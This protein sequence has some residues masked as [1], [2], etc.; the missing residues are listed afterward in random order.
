[1]PEQR[2]W[3]PLVEFLTAVSG[4]D[5]ELAA[6]TAAAHLAAEQFNAEIGAVIVEGELRA[7]TGF[8]ATRGPAGQLCAAK[9]GASE[10]ELPG[11]GKCELAVAAWAD[12]G[13][14]GRLVIGRVD[15][16]LDP[17]ERH[18]LMGMTR[19]LGLAL[20]NI[21]ALQTERTLRADREREAAERLQLLESLRVRQQLLEVLLDIQRSISHRAALPDVLRKVTDGASTLLGGCAVSLVL[22]DALDPARPIVACAAGE[23]AGGRP[24]PPGAEQLPADAPAADVL[25]ADA[26]V[27]TATV[28]IN[29]VS[30]GALVAESGQARSFAGA[31][32]GTL[33]AFAEHASLALTDA[34]TLE[35]MQE[36][37]HDPLTGLPNRALFLDRLEQALRAA[38][39]TDRQPSVLFID[40]DRFKAVNDTIGHAAGDE[41]LCAVAARLRSCVRSGDTAA[42][43]GGDE[44]AVLLEDAAN[45]L[46]CNRVAERIIAAIRRPFTIDRRE[47]FIGATVGIAAAGTSA[48]AADELLR[49]ADTAMYSAKRAGG[50]RT[51]T[52][53]SQMRDRLIERLELASELQHALARGHLS[54]A[55]Q[56]IVDL[57]S[58]RPTGVEALARWT[59]PGRGVVPPRTFIPIAEEIGIIGAIG[60]WIL[61]AGCRQLR[62]W[63]QVVPD[64][65][66]SVNVSGRQLE[67]DQILDDVE[68]ALR[69]N[70]LPGRALTLE[71]TERALAAGR[72]DIAVRLA[73]LCALDVAIAVDDFGIGYSALRYLRQLPID[74]LKIDKPFIDAIGTDSTEAALSH[75]MLQLASAMRLWTVA[76]GIETVEQLE[77]LRKLECDT[78]QGFLFSTP[79]G[80]DELT[81]YLHASVGDARSEVTGAT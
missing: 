30:A 61:A 28:H 63:R 4:H 9:P 60:H 26:P 43:F 18:L 37:F 12:G 71:I 80:E 8:G 77:Q 5:D 23:T 17:G 15:E 56:P 27:L 73:R 42:R 67:D 3:Q 65:T 47:V 40:L 62:S 36:A 49:N 72:D 45:S 70:G 81:A 7:V 14:T 24:G 54:I 44:F 41:L 46:E 16:P 53:E 38:G 25:A 19:V 34:K 50:G 11:I 74:T 33:D 6:A 59:S 64:L 39:R 79:L 31:D 66:L 76:E 58:R 48:P 21:A 32:R 68:R 1:M 29:G 35:A 20:R 22:D 2:S 55:Y 52:F 75:A 13:W 69:A 10:I 78:G 51:A 57:V